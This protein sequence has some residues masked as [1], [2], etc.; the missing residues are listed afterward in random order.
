MI[1]FPGCTPRSGPL[2]EGPDNGACLALWEGS[3][4]SVR[5]VR[6]AL[7]V[8]VAFLAL[9]WALQVANWAD[10][11]RLD[12]SFGILPHHLSRLPDI[13]TAPFLHQSWQHIEG[14]SLPLF[15]LGFMAAYRGVKKFLLVTLI[16]TIVS[17]LGV[18][19]F[20]SST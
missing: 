11:Y 10:G 1:R 20:Q 4:M 7:I 16:V 17:G 12:G 13:F 9:I 19:L 14:N 6:N 15:V 2:I 3:G 5:N 8:M 18:W